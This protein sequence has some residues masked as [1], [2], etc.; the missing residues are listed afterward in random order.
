MLRR[1]R[2]AI[3]REASTA[4]AEAVLKALK[5]Q[6]ANAGLSLNQALESV[7]GKA[8]EAQG[9]NLEAMGNFLGTV[10][11]LSMKRAA[12]V[13]GRAGGKAR[14]RKAAV[15]KAASECVT[16]ITGGGTSEQIV[17]HFRDGHDKRAAWEQYQREQ[18]RGNDGG[19]TSGGN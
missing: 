5:E 19:N 3:V 4:A 12:S 2:D 8:I 14:A 13:L 16:C 9:R 18:Q 15:A 17:A 1:T 6:Q 7:M 11:D 10:T